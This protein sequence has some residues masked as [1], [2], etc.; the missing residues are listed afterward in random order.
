MGNV[1]CSH[2]D[3]V[4][5]VKPNS[6]GCEECEKTGDKWVEVRVCKLCGHTGCCDSS[7]NTHARK[8]F[9]ETKHPIIESIDASW[10]WCYVDN[11]YVE[12]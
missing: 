12:K 10:R 2:L 5:D 3:Q 7:Q 8:H 9:E 11:G 1:Q 4:K 6:S